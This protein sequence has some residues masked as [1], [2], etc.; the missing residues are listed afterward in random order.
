MFHVTRR[1]TF[2]V[3]TSDA[4]LYRARKKE[5]FHFGGKSQ[6]AEGNKLSLPAQSSCGT[7]SSSFARPP[8]SS[9]WIARVSPIKQAI[10]RTYLFIWSDEPRSRAR[11]AQLPTAPLVI[12]LREFPETRDTRHTDESTS[13]K[14][15][16]H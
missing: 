10:S 9:N 13:R 6:K 14:N 8:F 11:N 12:K 16:C 7:L 1:I 15:R 3:Y 5:Y 4:S 2:H